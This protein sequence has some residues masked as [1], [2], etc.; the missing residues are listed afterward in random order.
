MLNG[1]NQYFLS[2]V[3][4]VVGGYMYMKLDSVSFKILC[5]D[6][7]VARGGVAWFMENGGKG[8]LANWTIEILS[9]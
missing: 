1:L 8:K 3:V 7:E 4:V 5:M 2:F 9:K 6:R